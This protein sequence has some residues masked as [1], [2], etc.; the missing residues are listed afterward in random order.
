MRKLSEAQWWWLLHLSWG[1]TTGR[2]VPTVTLEALRR[3]GLV[4]IE[5]VWSSGP[6]GAQD[7]WS[8]HITDAGKALCFARYKTTGA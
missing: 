7:G 2:E 8:A 3:R 6:N 4:S 5:G 1:G